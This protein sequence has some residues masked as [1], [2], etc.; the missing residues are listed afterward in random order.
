MLRKH[1]PTIDWND[2]KIT[3]NDEQCTTWCLNSS[4]VAYAI[5]EEKAVE[6]NFITRFSEIQAKKNLRV[7]IK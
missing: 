4:Q 6:E 3:F 2:K 5:L 7:R 1:N